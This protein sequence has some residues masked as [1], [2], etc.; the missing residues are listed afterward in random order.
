MKFLRKGGLAPVPW[1]ISDLLIAASL[2]VAIFVAILVVICLASSDDGD[3][4]LTV[5]VISGITGAAMLLA[6][7]VMGPARYRISIANLGFRLPF[8]T[9]YSLLFLPV[10]ALLG[11]LAFAGV[12]SGVLTLAGGEDLLP[13]SLPEEIA[14]EGPAVIG[15]FAVIA[16]WGPLAEEVFF[17]GF[18]FAG[19]V[20]RLGVRRAA[21][22]SSVIFALVHSDPRVM[23]PI[24]VTGMLLAWLYYKT[25]SIWSSFA[26]HSMQNALAL[27]VSL[28]G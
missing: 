22:L 21:L 8:S 15:S 19:L 27:G 1:K 28:A 25:G 7:W 10:A 24:F 26:A 6:S 11:S 14:L 4:G 13:E 18:I 17:R 16:L 12:Y 9:S 20:R 2:V 5:V 23:V 3:L